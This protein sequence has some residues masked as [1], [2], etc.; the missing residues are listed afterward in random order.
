[1][2]Q[3]DVFTQRDLLEEAFLRAINLLFCRVD[4]T[5]EEGRGER[6]DSQLTLHTAQPKLPYSETAAKLK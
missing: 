6:V 3:Q 4:W 2:G 5:E 1:M